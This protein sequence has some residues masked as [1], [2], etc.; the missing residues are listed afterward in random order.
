MLDGRYPSQEFAELRAAHRLGS[1][2]RARPRPGGARALAVTNGGTIPDRGLFSGEPARRAPG[3][4][5]RRGDG[6]RGA[7]R[8]D[9][10]CWAPPTWRIEEITR[11]R[12]I[13][14]PGP[15][16]ARGGAVLEGRRR[17]PP[18]ELG[19]AIGAF[20]RWA[21]DQ[22]AEA[23]AARLRP[24]RARGAQ[25]AR[26]PARAAGGDSR[27]ARRTA[28]IV[29]ERFRDEIGDWRLCVLSPVR[30]PRPRRLGAGARARGSATRFGLDAGRDLVATTASSSTCPTP[31]SRP[32]PSWCCSSRTRSRSWWSPSSAPPPC[33]AH[34][35]ARTPPARCSSRA[36]ARAS[37]RRCGSSASSRSRC[38]RWRS[39]YRQLPDHPRD[40]PRV[41]ARRVRRAGARRACCASL[42]RREL[43][44]VEVETATA[45]PFASSLL[46]DYVATYMYEGD[47]PNAER[48]AAALAL[49]RDLLREL[50]GQEELRELIDPA[51]LASVEDDLQWLSEAA[52]RAAGR[53]ALHDM[54]R[55][56]GDLSTRRGRAA[57]RGRRRRALDARCAGGRATSGP[58]PGRRRGALD[59]RRRMPAFTATRSAWSRPA[60]SPTRSLPT[61]LTR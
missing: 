36:P 40:L 28:P 59:R 33:S 41:P 37:A 51:A 24:R 54:L 26:L 20:A 44:L 48:R 4:R 57:G 45:S 27:G 39:R 21:V 9:A 8:A 11:D 12:V 14:T 56:L 31:T 49:D 3:R 2:R 15:G 17:G 42:T 13:V 46:F 25:P 22:D 23:L 1:A 34:V 32:A 18:R 58:G 6:L 38:S 10:S 50:L 7:R 60:G 29:V 35:S 47:T 55:L 61:Y 30:R 19:A 43:S 53:D 16:R 52:R 5:A